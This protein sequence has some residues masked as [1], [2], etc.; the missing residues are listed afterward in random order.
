MEAYMMK[1][2]FVQK[3]L[4]DQWMRT[5]HT[6]AVRLGDSARVGSEEVGSWASSQADGQGDSQEEHELAKGLEIS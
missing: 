3:G 6:T 2:T 4:G 5:G 1:W